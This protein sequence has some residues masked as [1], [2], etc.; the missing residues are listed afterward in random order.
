MEELK[1][2]KELIKKELKEVETKGLTSANLES[3][4]KMVDILKDL[5]E[6][7]LEGKEMEQYSQRYNAGRGGYGADQGGYN[8]GQGGYNAGQGQGYGMPQ[9]MTYAMPMPMYMPPPPIYREG[10]YD[11]GGY[12]ARRYREGGYNEGGYNEGGYRERGRSYN[13][14]D[15]RMKERIGRLI[16]GAERYEYGRERYQHG[17]SHEAMEEGLEKMMYAICVLVETAMDAAQSPKE[18]EI[19]RKHI[20]KIKEL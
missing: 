6:V 18:K 16:D 10:G 13:G 8:A 17:G 2:L 19:I 11:E 5:E 20:N 15:E 4:S 7:N 14:N 9:P 3:T 12:G 1:Q